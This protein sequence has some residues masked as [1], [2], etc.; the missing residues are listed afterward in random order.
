MNHAHYEMGRLHRTEAGG[1]KK[2]KRKRRRKSSRRSAKKEVMN[3]DEE[4]NELKVKRTATGDRKQREREREWRSHKE[5][6]GRREKVSR[7]EKVKIGEERGQQDAEK[8]AHDVM[9]WVEVKR[10]KAQGRHEDDGRIAGL[11]R[12][13]PRRMGPVSA[14]CV[15]ERQGR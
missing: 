5:E 6:S 13:S 15:T 12:S 10:K 2:E 4:G 11:S 14:G 7:Q 3:S 9:D 8:V 1:R